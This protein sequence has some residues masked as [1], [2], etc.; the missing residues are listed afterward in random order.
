MESKIK[1]ERACW[2]DILS[3]PRPNVA[4]QP[5][6]L[7]RG[8]RAPTSGPAPSA[9][10]M[11]HPIVELFEFVT[12]SSRGFATLSLRS[13]ASLVWYYGGNTHASLVLLMSR[14]L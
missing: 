4:I 9:T 13:R 7:A 2:A 12:I 14:A 8:D 10:S 11:C 3:R 5:R 1:K 6:G